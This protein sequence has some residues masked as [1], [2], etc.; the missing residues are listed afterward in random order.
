MRKFA[1]LLIFTACSAPNPWKYQS[2]PVDDP[3]FDSARLTYVASSPLQF[4]IMR[5]GQEIEGFLNLTKHKF[6]SSKK[7]VKAEFRMGEDKIIAELPVL[8]GNMRVP[9]PLP[10]TNQLISALQEGKE[11]V[12]L[13]DGFEER[14]NPNR[15]FSFYEKLQRKD[16]FINYL[17]LKGLF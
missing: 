3:I 7:T 12:I 1:L 11:V 14:L 4:E 16:S 6:S 10:L 17:P 8:E 5:L 13:V 15:F 2:I 9:L